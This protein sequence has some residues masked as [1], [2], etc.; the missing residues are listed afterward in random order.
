[1]TICCGS[2]D[3]FEFLKIS[4]IISKTVQDKGSRNEN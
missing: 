2:R 1:M 3:P 4:D